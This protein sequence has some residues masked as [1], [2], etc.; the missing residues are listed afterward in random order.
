MAVRFNQSPVAY[1]DK[2]GSVIT[3]KEAFNDAAKYAGIAIV[4]ALGSNLSWIAAYILPF[5][6]SKHVVQ[7]LLITVAIVHLV[8]IVSLSSEWSESRKTLQNQAKLQ[9]PQKKLL[10]LPTPA[11][12]PTPVAA[13]KTPLQTLASAATPGTPITPPS[14]TN[15]SKLRALDSSAGPIPSS[16]RQS[17][18]GR[19]ST[20]GRSAR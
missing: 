3:T 1:A 20:G 9:A 19:P 14:R 8:K 11:A 4:C 15:G 12:A 2:L 13:K 18:V 6:G 10:G 5:P 16:T 7:A 17:S